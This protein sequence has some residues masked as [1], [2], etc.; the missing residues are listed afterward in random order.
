MIPSNL[1]PGCT[2][3]EI[4]EA[5]GPEQGT[6]DV[7]G[8]TW[9]VQ[10]GD[11]QTDILDDEGDYH[12]TLPGLVDDERLLAAIVKYGKE[13]YRAGES[14]GRESFARDLRKLLGVPGID[15]I[16]ALSERIE[17]LGS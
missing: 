11:D 15:E 3:R 12:T 10:Y 2:N 14:W 13:R 7:N 9:Y 1:P 17:R 5:A 4:E 6:F 8:A 16:E